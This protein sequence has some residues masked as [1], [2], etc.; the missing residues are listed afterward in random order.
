MSLSKYEKHNFL[1]CGISLCEILN[2]TIKAHALTGL[3][4]L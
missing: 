4:G 2:R 3:V 1:C